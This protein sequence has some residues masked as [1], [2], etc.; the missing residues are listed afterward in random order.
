MIAMKI[1]ERR[2]RGR[3]RALDRDKALETALQL[4]WRH[5]YEG[6]SIADLTEAMGVAPPSLYSAFGSKERLYQEALDRYRASYGSFTERALAEEP[7]ARRAIERLLR[8]AV[9]VY[10]AGPEPLGCMLAA[11]ALTCSAEHK[12]IAAALAQRRL[13]AIAAIKSRFDRAMAEGEL[14]PSTD[15]MALA[16]YYGAVVQGLSIQARDGVAPEVLTSLVDVALGVWPKRKG[17]R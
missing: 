3:P 6:T 16:A 4:F 2:P 10:S 12:E 17:Q 5:G 7:T 15:T 14:A 9:R 8:D 11:G 13:S 1:S